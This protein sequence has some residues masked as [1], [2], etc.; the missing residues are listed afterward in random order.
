[1]NKLQLS[2]EE[3]K[4]IIYAYHHDP[5]QVLGMRKVGEGGIVVRAFFPDVVE[6]YV[7]DISTEK[8]FKME[9]IRD[10]GL[11]QYHFKDRDDVFKYQFRKVFNE[12]YEQI[13]YDPYSFMPVLTD[14]DQHLFSI[15]DHHHTYE[16]LGAH[17]M[18][19]DNIKGTHFAVWAPSAKR[20]SVIGDFNNWDGRKH[21]MRVLGSTGI[22]EIFIPGMEQGEK[23]KYEIKS[24]KDEIIIK[25]DPHAFYAETR[26]KTASIVYDINDFDWTDEEWINKRNNSNLLEEPIS[27]YEVHLGSW[28]RI[29]EEDNRYLTYRELAPKL[30]NYVDK[31]G[32]THIELMPITEHPFDGSWGYQVLGFFAPTSRFGEPKD[33]MWFV[34]YLHERGIGV[35]LD[36]VP[37]HFPKD[38]HGLSYFDGS[39]MY[40]YAD[41]RKGEHADWGTLVF[42]YGRYEVSEFLISSGLFWLDKYHI[43]GLRVDAVASMLYLDYGRKDKEW[44]PNEYG[45]NENLEAVKFIK[46]FNELVHK[47]HKG[48]MT[49]AEESTAWTGVTKPTYVGGLGFTFKWNMGW[50]HDTLEYI[51]K[52]SIYR[53]YHHGQITFGLVYAFS[54]NYIL[55][56]SHDEIVHGKGS[57]INKMPGD[58]WQKFANLRAY[59]GFQYTHPG[60]KL[61]FMGGEFGMWN[62]WWEERSIDWHLLE[63]KNNRGL[64]VFLRDLLAIYKKEPALHQ[65][66]YHWASFEWI[67]SHDADNNVFSYI[68]RAKFPDDHLVIVINFAAVPRYDYRVGV[69]SKMYYKE[70]LNSDSESY[71][72]SNVG[73]DGGRMAEEYQWQ[74]KPFS[75]SITL[76]P[77]GI[78][79]LKPTP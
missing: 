37:A 22:W 73:N 7:I 2:D 16:K 20:V 29:P 42:D 70:I 11:F 63:N 54:E 43:D 67:D 10:E 12:E 18:K 62:E 75:I 8:E 49:I 64:Q 36:W 45:G 1:M 53:K 30:A 28:M 66:D 48:V 5:F 56:L 50:M 68:R 26:P 46:K 79:I 13:I 6:A 33:F 61:I 21:Q 9:K 57:M 34:N 27:V 65:F 78:L 23:Y 14:F 4:K 74:G 24:A 15:G 69:P 41:P 35:I 60:K 17:T 31:M 77:L 25:A 39:P 3:I 38:S 71:M 59:Y 58:E 47:Y 40:E 51:S 52:D 55:P 32:Y 19:I 44:V 72:G 76:P